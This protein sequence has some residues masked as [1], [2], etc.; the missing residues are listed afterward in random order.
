[1]PTKKRNTSCRFLRKV[2]TTYQKMREL[3]NDYMMDKE[4]RGKFN[5]FVVSILAP[6]KSHNSKQQSQNR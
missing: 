4:E 2:A 5:I 1:M 3:T 6:E